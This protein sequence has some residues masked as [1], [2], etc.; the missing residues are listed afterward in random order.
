[1][2]R[3]YRMIKQEHFFYLGLAEEVKKRLKKEKE[4]LRDEWQ[5][6]VDEKQRKV[7]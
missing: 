6:Q 2:F 7:R 4:N 3:Q 5:G 1:M